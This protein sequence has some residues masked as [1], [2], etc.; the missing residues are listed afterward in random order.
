MAAFI[1]ERRGGFGLRRRTPVHGAQRC[2]APAR[3]G[4]DDGGHTG[5]IGRRGRAQE[6]GGKRRA[7]CTMHCVIGRTMPVLAA[8]SSG[9]GECQGELRGWR[10]GFASLGRLCSEHALNIALGGTHNA[11]FACQHC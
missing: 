3:E 4:E 11:C 1:G 2:K 7:Q 10:R 5:T 8:A 9:V 6:R